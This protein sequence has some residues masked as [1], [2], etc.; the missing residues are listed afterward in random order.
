MSKFSEFEIKL[1]LFF[2]KSE[3]GVKAGLQG[4]YRVGGVISTD[5]DFFTYSIMS[6]CNATILKNNLSEFKTFSG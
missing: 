5:Y 3:P 4:F 2:W 1:V 6:L